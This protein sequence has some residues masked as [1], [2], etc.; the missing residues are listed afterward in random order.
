MRKSSILPGEFIQQ[1]T[2]AFTGSLLNQCL[3]KQTAT[4]LLLLNTARETLPEELP[5]WL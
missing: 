5:I 2:I 1:N 3:N 4:L